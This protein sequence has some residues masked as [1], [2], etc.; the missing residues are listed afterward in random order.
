VAQLILF[1]VYLAGSL[2]VLVIQPKRNRAIESA[3]KSRADFKKQAEDM[4]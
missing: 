2:Y 1:G 3:R 4:Q